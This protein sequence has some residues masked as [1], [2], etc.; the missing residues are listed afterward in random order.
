MRRCLF[1]CVAVLVGL[2]SAPPALAQRSPQPKTG[3]VASGPITFDVDGMLGA[4][5][6]LSGDWVGTITPQ[7]DPDGS[8][9]IAPL[10]IQV[11]K[12]EA[13]GALTTVNSITGNG[14]YVFTNAGYLRFT[15]DYTRTSG[16]LNTNL[17]RGF[18]ALSDV[19][20]GD[21]MIDTSA[22]ATATKQDITNTSLGTSADAASGTGS[23]H[24]KLR[25]IAVTGIPITGVPTDPFGANGDAASA[26]GSISAKLRFIA[27]TGIPI[28]GVPTDPFGANGDAASAT[29]SIS[30]KLRFIAATGIPVTAL[31]ATAATT[32]NQAI[33]NTALGAPSDTIAA[34][35]GDGSMISQFK[36]L[37]T[38]GSD[39][40]TAILDLLN[41]GINVKQIGGVAPAAAQTFDFDSGAGTVT[42]EAM[43]LMVA[44][45]GGPV[46]LPGSSTTGLYTDVRALPALPA[47]T[48][49][50]GRVVID[51]QVGNG[52]IPSAYTS[53]G[54]TEDEHAACAGACNIGAILVTNTN[55]AAR[56]FRCANLTAANT[57]PGTSTPVID[58]AIPGHTSGS[59]FSVPI[60]VAGASF[61]TAA[62]CWLVTGAAQSDVAEVAANEIKV[63]YFIK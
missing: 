5:V 41:N 28:T 49:A 55:A 20:V 26:T 18:A 53:V 2:A 42:R 48:N 15:L 43:G 63:T 34:V 8:G 7:G 38:D 14:T 24:A 27:A 46:L 52:Y 59:G 56:Y 51:A 32:T 4:T 60:P 37:T 11:K 44:A 61:T 33:T 50:I 62:T 45:S 3:I 1:V 39:T 58:A 23:I 17:T 19:S 40:K 29:G 16:T 9:A 35:G 10:T 54:T 22:L 36:R 13:T 47:G 6:T 25:Q 57:T 12:I 31:P 21:V 30:A